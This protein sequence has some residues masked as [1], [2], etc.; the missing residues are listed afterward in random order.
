MAGR[1]AEVKVRVKA[2]FEDSQ[3]GWRLVGHLVGKLEVYV[4]GMLK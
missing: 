4:V 2:S 1:Q 3:S